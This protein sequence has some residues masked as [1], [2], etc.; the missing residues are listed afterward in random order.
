MYFLSFQRLNV[1]VTR[2]ISLLI[3][4]GNHE[5]LECDDNWAELILH[6]NRNGALIRESKIL[7]QRIKAPE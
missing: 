4:V 1:M 6:C 5:A 2:A 3:V 7:H